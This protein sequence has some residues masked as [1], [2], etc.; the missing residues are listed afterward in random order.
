[1]VEATVWFLVSEC[2]S[3]ALKHA[4]A[5]SLCVRV[6][7]E[8]ELLVTISDDGVGGACETRGTGLRGLRARVESLGGSLAVACLARDDA[9]SS[10]AASM[11]GS[12]RNGICRVIEIELVLR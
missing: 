2:L 7:V 1:M 11:S 8:G 9:Y 6:V 4:E 12:I 5:T 10:P 3:N